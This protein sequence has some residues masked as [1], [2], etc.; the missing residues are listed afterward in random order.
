MCSRPH[1][2]AF[3]WR[4]P[5]ART[6]KRPRPSIC[7]A[8][9]WAA[10]RPAGSIAIWWWNRRWRSP[11]DAGDNGEALDYGQFTIAAAPPAG[12]DTAKLEA[13]IDAEIALLARQGHRRRRTRRRQEP[14]RRRCDQGARQPARAR[15]DRRHGAHHRHH[16][17]SAGILARA[18]R[19]GQRRRGAAGGQGRAAAQGKQRDRHP[20]AERGRGR[21]R[22][23]PAAAQQLPAGAIQ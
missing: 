23:G 9:S 6:C 14:H 18:N 7:W 15:P 20:A 21:P 16:A 13:A 19:R 8:R 10:G 2:S 22:S 11:C 1:G 5:S 17:G 12:V 4:R 3:I